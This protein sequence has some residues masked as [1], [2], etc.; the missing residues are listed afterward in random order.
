MKIIYIIFGIVMLTLPQLSLAD[1]CRDRCSE[2]CA[3]CNQECPMDQPAGAACH[4]WCQVAYDACI[5]KCSSDSER[6]TR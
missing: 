6:T 5:K 2:I 3:E 1:E 4:A